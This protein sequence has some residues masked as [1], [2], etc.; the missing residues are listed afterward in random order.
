VKQAKFEPATIETIA[1][2]TCRSL[3]HGRDSSEENLEYA[4]S[5]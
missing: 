1:P 2:K 5:I 3:S 4:G